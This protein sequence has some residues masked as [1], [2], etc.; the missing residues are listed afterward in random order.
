[1]PTSELLQTPLGIFFVGLFSLMVGSFLNVVIYRVP[2]MMDREEKQY[3]WQV[4]HGEDSVCPEILKQRF[5]LLVP[6]SRCPHCGHRIRAIE[7][8]PVISWLFLKGKCSGCGAAISARY[9]LVELLTAALSVIVAFHYHDPL[10][11][12]FAL[13]FTWTLIALCF[14][15]AE[16]QLLPDRLTLP[17]LWLGILAALFNVFINLESSVIGAMIG[18]LSLWSVYWLFKLITGREGMGY[19]DFKLLACLCAWQGA[20][21]L[22][23][24]LFSAAILGMIYALGIGLRMGKP[25]PFGP[26]L[27]IAGWLT[28]LYGAQIGQ[29]FGYFPA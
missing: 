28:F 18:Y 3:A 2:V 6:A 16:H 21:M 7:N 19:G 9:L 12:G 20:W 24:I 11:L 8:I 25:M 14:I 5:N 17:L 27:A 4:F 1:M 22:P 15:D 26:F 23:I 29:L 10:S 13:V